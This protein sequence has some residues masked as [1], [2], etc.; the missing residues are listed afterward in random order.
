MGH[1]EEQ[2][3]HISLLGNTQFYSLCFMCPLISSEHV[4]NYIQSY[5]GAMHYCCL[6]SCAFSKYVKVD[7]DIVLRRDYV[8]K[9]ML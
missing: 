7:V 4:V 9:F 5:I 6:F 1:V 8:C 3:N 2:C